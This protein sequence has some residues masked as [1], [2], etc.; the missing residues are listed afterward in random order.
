MRKLIVE[1]A[2]GSV[3][4]GAVSKK[5]VPDSLSPRCEDQITRRPYLDYNEINGYFKGKRNLG[6]WLNREVLVKSLTYWKP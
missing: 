3:A 6:H 2:S 1:S 5:N 4:P